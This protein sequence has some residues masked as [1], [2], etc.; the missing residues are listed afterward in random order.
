[1]HLNPFRADIVAKA[2]DRSR[3]SYR[4]FVLDEPNDLVDFLQ[5]YLQLSKRPERRRELMR[6]VTEDKGATRA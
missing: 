1:M 3:S 6:M 4:A 5:A 2:E